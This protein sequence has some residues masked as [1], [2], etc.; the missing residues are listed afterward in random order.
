MQTLSNI[1]RSRLGR[2]MRGQLFQDI[3]KE[4]SYF[5]DELTQQLLLIDNHVKNIDMF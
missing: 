5:L 1:I 4:P 2:S 3:K